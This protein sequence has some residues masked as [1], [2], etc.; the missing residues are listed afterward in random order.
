MLNIGFGELMVV[1]L[2]AYVIVGP[3]DLPRVA[4]WIGRQ[5][6]RLRRMNREFREAS[7]WDDL[8]SEAGDIR[9]EITD[10]V[11]TAEQAVRRAGEQEGAGEE[12]PAEMPRG[13]SADGTEEDVHEDRNH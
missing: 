4:R 11:R 12:N 3:R 13:R 2:I 8:M 6:R 9:R 1:L 7:G 10:T 5:I